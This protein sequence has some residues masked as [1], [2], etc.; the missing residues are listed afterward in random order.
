[1]PGITRTLE[2]GFSLVATLIVVALLGLVAAAGLKL[3]SVVHRR[4]AELAL[5]DVGLAYSR[6]LGSY[7]RAT[8][9]GQPDAPRT[10]QELLLDPRL[11]T[12]QRHLRK[13]FADPLSGSA[14]WGLELDEDGRIVGIYSLA[15]GQPIKR[16]GFPR[17]F[18]QFAGKKHYR[19]WKFERSAEDAAQPG[20]AKR[21][22]LSPGFEAG[23]DAPGD[24][25]P[26]ERGSYQPR[27]PPPG[28][29]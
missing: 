10:L 9:A 16:A 2:R 5:L 19:D 25:E 24:D 4:N 29:P 18:A 8:P 21:G 6:A 26:G 22:L 15:E 1:M 28:R 20:A 3:G 17:R 23:D 11:P 7:A 14:E 12:R 13:L 27:L